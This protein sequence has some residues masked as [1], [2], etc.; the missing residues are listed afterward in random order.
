[1]RMGGEGI[2]LQPRGR[3][4]SFYQWLLHRALRHRGIVLILAVWMFGF[5]VWLLP[6]RIENPPALA[7]VYNGTIG[8]SWYAALRPVVNTLLGGASYQFF[9]HVPQAEFF[10][11][12]TGTCLVIQ[13]DFPQG[14]DVNITGAV[15]RVFEQD[16]LHAGAP[17]VTTRMFSRTLLLR[18]D[19]PDSLVATP[20]PRLLRARCLYLAA[21]TGGLGVSVAGIGAG[22]SGGMEQ[23][24]AFSVRVLGYDYSRVKQIAES[25]RKRLLRNPRVASADI[26]RSFGCW[27]RRQEIALHVDRMAVTRYGLTAQ[28]VAATVRSR[29]DVLLVGMPVKFDGMQLPCVVTFQGSDCISVE[30]LPLS[31]VPRKNSPPVPLRSLLVM[32]QRAAPSEIVREDQQYVRWVSFEYKGPYRHA[33]AFLEETLKALS[34]PEGYRIDRTGGSTIADDDK[35]ALLLAVVAALALVFMVTASLYESLLKPL[36]IMLSIPF[37]YIGV[38]LAFVLTGMPFGR[39]GYISVIFLSGIA[40]ANA[41]VIVDFIAGKEKAGERSAE[42]IVSASVCRLRPVLMTT[43]TSA[44]S[45]LPLLFG[46]RSD[47]WY[48]LALGTF[49]GLVTSAALTLIV[50][51]VVYAIAHGIKGG[52]EREEPPR[53]PSAGAEAVH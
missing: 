1:M 50:I 17:R 8:G 39:G 3:A 43:L 38:F 47:V 27:A 44:G 36:V 19:F 28:T 24:P 15:A 31:E 6:M 2:V 35:H 49:G 25:L 7:S 16:L 32:Q 18:V 10:E 53:I 42:A 26:D 45:L 46:E 52:S 13:A 34:L 30:D 40:I 29:T 41:I 11:Q 37:A 14:T 9:W 5:P 22:Y 21:Q 23:Q 12:E 4:V 20:L 48:M 51:P 33:E